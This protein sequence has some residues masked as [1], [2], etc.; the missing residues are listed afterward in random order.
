MLLLFFF[1]WGGGGERR[2]EITSELLFK[3]PFRTGL[4]SIVNSYM[5]YSLEILSFSILSLFVF[6]M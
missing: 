3:K 4:I 6:V 5:E 2:F 1:F